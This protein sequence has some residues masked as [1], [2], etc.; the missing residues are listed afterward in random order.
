MAKPDIILEDL[1]Q[2]LIAI[3]EG[4]GSAFV[5]IVCEFV[6]IFWQQRHFMNI[7]RGLCPERCSY[8]VGNNT[9]M[10]PRPYQTLKIDKILEQLGVFP[11]GLKTIY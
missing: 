11:W 3:L 4:F 6:N 9:D 7:S 1:D 5:V 2:R 8:C 10:N